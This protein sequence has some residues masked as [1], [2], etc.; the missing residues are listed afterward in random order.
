MVDRCVSL[1]IEQQYFARIARHYDAYVHAR[2]LDDL[3][4]WLETGRRYGRTGIL[5]AACGTGR[6]L[7]PLARSGLA[8]DGFDF[9]S[10]LLDELRSKLAA[11]PSGVQGRV[12]LFP[13][14]MRA[15]DFGRTY[16]LIIVPFHSLQY[17]LTLDDQIAALRCFERHLAGGGHLAFNVF[18]PRYELLDRIASEQAELEWQDPAEPSVTV[19]RACLRTRVDRL[20]QVY[21][22]VYILRFFAGGEFVKEERAVMRTAYYTYPQLQLLLTSTGFK[23]VEEYGSFK[24]EPI[25]ILQ[26]M[27]I[28][29]QKAGPESA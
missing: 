13:G 6:V 11:E 27:I 17:L 12:S 16:G 22:A 26:E 23:I 18:Y 15:F 5:E 19:K 3:P 28:V 8:I 7:L 14:D 21:E 9:C 29:A 10:A 24:K 2:A 20:N 4:F 25:H 1:T